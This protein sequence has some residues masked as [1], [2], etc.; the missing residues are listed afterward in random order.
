VAPVQILNLLQSKPIQNSID[1]LLRPLR[2]IPLHPE[3]P[4]LSII[5]II[6]TLI[7]IYFF[8][9][10]LGYSLAVFGYNPHFFANYGIS[11]S[12]IFMVGIIIANALAGLSGYLFAQSNG[13]ADINMGFGKLLLCVTALILGKT[14]HKKSLSL[15]TPIVGLFGYFTLQQLLLKVGFDL[16]YFT[17]VQAMVIVIILI[18]HYK[19]DESLNSDHLGV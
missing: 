2:I 6:C 7:T 5:F 9:T 16:R 4:F 1:I 11:S 14:I 12:Y 18:S 13:F 17:A 15:I 19:K 10:E 8:K 3:V